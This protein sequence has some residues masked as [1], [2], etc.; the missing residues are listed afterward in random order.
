L[1]VKVLDFNFQNPQAGVPWI[2]SLKCD[3]LVAQPGDDR[4]LF[5]RRFLQLCRGPDQALG[6]SAGLVGTETDATFKVGND[7]LA[8]LRIIEGPGGC[9]KPALG[10]API[11]NV[12][13]GIIIMRKTR[14]YKFACYEVHLDRTLLLV[15]ACK[16]VTIKLKCRG[17]I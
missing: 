16:L 12:H 15:A 6:V 17:H 3:V 13:P 10:G 9:G 8:K 7:Q 5:W 2:A 1:R 4:D 14:G 11:R